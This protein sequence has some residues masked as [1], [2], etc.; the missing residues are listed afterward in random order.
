GVRTELVPW[1]SLSVP[2]ARFPVSRCSPL[3]PLISPPSSASMQPMYP[4]HP[5]NARRRGPKLQIPL[6]ADVA[7]YHKCPPKTL[8][9]PVKGA[10]TGAPAPAR[11]RAAP[12]I[13]LKFIP[14]NMRRPSPWNE[15]LT[16]WLESCEQKKA[17]EA[18]AASSHDDESA[19]SSCGSSSSSGA[20]SGDTVTTDFSS[21]SSPRKANLPENRVDHSNRAPQPSVQH[22]Q[23]R[24]RR[25]PCRVPLGVA[26]SA[27]LT[28][29][30]WAELLQLQQATIRPMHYHPPPKLLNIQTAYFPGLDAAVMAMMQPSQ[31]PQPPYY[32]RSP[33]A[34][35]VPHQQWQQPTQQL[36]SPH[37]TYFKAPDRSPQHVATAPGSSGC[38]TDSAH[39]SEDKDRGQVCSFC[40][41]HAVHEADT[42]GGHLPRL[43]DRGCWRG[44]VLRDGY[45]IVCPR[46]L[47]RVCSLCGATG[48]SAHQTNYCPS[49]KRKTAN[50]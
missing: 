15:F 3:A 21:I 9:Q 26:R 50:Y 13:H 45:T 41:Q 40:Y 35:Y 4:L 22:L 34:P 7:R 1:E 12:K 6:D 8:L 5:Q 25:Y 48:Q 31:Q 42:R 38:S 18:A 28:P 32:R 19:A 29:G 39:G 16:D 23:P 17:A 24:P 20:C 36:Q 43:T 37:G 44:H 30:Q 27:Q 11:E 49:T 46:L 14:A 33:A 10:A 2:G 47:R